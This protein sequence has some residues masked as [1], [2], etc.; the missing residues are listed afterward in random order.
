MTA[1]GMIS[2][3]RRRASRPNGRASRGPK[4]PAGKASS[5]SNALRHGL[6]RPACLDPALAKEIAALTRAIAGPAAGT[7]RFSMACRIAVEQID[8]ARVRRA[9]CA[10]LSTVPLDGAAVARAAALDRYERRALSR[11]KAAMRAFDAA[12]APAPVAGAGLKPAATPANAGAIPRPPNLAERTQEKQKGKQQAKEEDKQQEGKLTPT[13]RTQ[14]TEI[15][16]K[17]TRAKQ[18]QA[19]QTQADAVQ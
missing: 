7:E 9:R 4:T 12:F 17:Q 2:E 3:A 8:V 19:K 11:R 10:L 6:S 18:T 14:A 15:L 13:E 5:A 1:A 16:A